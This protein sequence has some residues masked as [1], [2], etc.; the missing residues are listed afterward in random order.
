MAE[1]A[2]LA[3]RD[4]LILL[5]IPPGAPISEEDL[6]RQLG[7]G[8]TPIRESI[9]RLALENLIEVFPR[10]GTFASDIQIT[11]LAAISEV[12]IQL[13]GYAALLA[14]TR[15]PPDSKGPLDELLAELGVVPQTPEALMSL[16]A[17]VHRFVYRAT[18]NPYLEDTLNRHLNLSLRIW[19]LVLDR[20][21]HLSERVREHEDLLLAIQ[22]GDGERAKDIAAT[23]VATFEREIRSVL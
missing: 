18:R 9:K 2:Y 4:Q 1:R 13:E 8:R 22:R 11:D 23:H 21:P 17:R 14:A 20:L 3:L 12:R 19:C 6:M 10:R 7:M 15:L 16:D 5:K